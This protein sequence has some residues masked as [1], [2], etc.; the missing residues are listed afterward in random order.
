MI[1]CQHP[2]GQHSGTAPCTLTMFSTAGLHPGHRIR[3]ARKVKVVASVQSQTVVT[4]RPRRW[5]EAA[6]DGLRWLWRRL[7]G[8]P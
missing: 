7:S 4:V 1:P 2:P 3:V 8:S 5:R 6:A